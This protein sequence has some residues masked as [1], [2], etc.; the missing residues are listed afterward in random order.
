MMFKP[1]I[2]GTVMLLR[3]L[4]R[5]LPMSMKWAKK[6]DDPRFFVHISYQDTD[7]DLLKK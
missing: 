1:Y 7:S 3:A 5:F 2:G 6:V 4:F